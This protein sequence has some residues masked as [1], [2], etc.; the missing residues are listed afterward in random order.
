MS[1]R[2]NL[3]KEAEQEIASVGDNE[4]AKTKINDRVFITMSEKALWDN[5]DKKSNGG[6]K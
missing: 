2:L 1:R 5:F 6:K 3:S 4:V